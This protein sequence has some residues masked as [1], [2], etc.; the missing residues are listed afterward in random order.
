MIKPLKIMYNLKS[1]SYINKIRES[2]VNNKTFQ[3]NFYGKGNLEDD[4]GTS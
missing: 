1:D 4:H 3:P 2:I